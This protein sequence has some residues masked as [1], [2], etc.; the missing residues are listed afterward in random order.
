MELNCPGKPCLGP[1]ACAA[2]TTIVV[3][4]L[5]VLRAPLDL[6]TYLPGRTFVHVECFVMRTTVVAFLLSSFG[7]A[8][9]GCSSNQ[10]Q[11][12]HWAGKTFLLSIPTDNWAQPRGFGDQIA[13]VVPQFIIGLQAGTGSDLAVTLGT[14]K[15]GKQNLCNIT[16]P[17]TASESQYPK[18]SISA[19]TFPI[20]VT[21]DNTDAGAPITVH[22]TVR[23]AAFTDV[24][25][26]DTAA[27]TGIFEA[28]ID[29]GE[30]YPLFPKAM[31][32]TPQGVCD[33]LSGASVT[34]ASCALCPHNDKTEC[35]TVKAE[36]L[37][38]VASSAQIEQILVGDL[39]SSCP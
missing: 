21:S 8:L 6:S 2:I 15:D 31:P 36:Q 32:P 22:T 16:T 5:E 37:G 3:A 18:S 12:S 39:A 17:A 33:L 30:L 38:A 27:S 20:V 14:A 26:G 25:P 34:G 23:N 29:F 35:L 28:T 19:E 7:L 9:A 13:L 11:G 24:L 1:C 10:G 4:S